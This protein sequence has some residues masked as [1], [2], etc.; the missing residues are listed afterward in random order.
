LK[1]I[2]EKQRQQKQTTAKRQ[3]QLFKRPQKS[4]NM[5]N[6]AFQKTTE[7]Q[8]IKNTTFQKTTE[9][10]HFHYKKTVFWVRVDALD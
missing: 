7:K 10:Q 4:N 6:T 2:N 3:K 9:R 1:Y 5:K 8:Q